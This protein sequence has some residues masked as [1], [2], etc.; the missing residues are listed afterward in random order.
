M[1]NF[2]RCAAAILLLCLSLP[3]FAGKK[4]GPV[5][6]EAVL[7][8]FHMVD[9]GKFCTTSGDTSG[10]VHSNGN[11]TGTISGTT[12]STTSC[13]PRTAAMYTVVAGDH[14][15]TLTPH[16]SGGKTA[17]KAGTA[18]LTLGI[19]VIVWN[20]LEK[21]STLYGVLPGTA[22][23]LRSDEGIVYVKVGK[24]ESMYSIVSME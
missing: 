2:I 14:V 4:D 16:Q 3:C 13:H 5:Y 23:K 1:K 24:R 19:G 8:D 6:Q 21:S 12:S 10:T 20:S 15:L 11:N 17:A 9:D 18:F 7:K 22:I